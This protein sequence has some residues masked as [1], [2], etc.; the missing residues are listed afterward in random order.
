MRPLASS[1]SRTPVKVPFVINVLSPSFLACHWRLI[2][3]RRENVELG[4]RYP[5]VTNM[6][7]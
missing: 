7:C 5:Q 6:G 4:G 3:E 2:S 1:L